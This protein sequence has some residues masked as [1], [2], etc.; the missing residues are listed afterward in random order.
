MGVERIF[1][2]SVSEVISELPQPLAV[3]RQVQGPKDSPSRVKD[4]AP[5]L[6]CGSVVRNT[7]SNAGDMGL[8]PGQGTKIP[9]ASGQLSLCAATRACAL[10]QKS[11]M[12][13]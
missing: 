12:L 4:S 8:I 5:G 6:P 11:H 13:Q 9:H 2:Q 3:I 1:T 7:P 10:Q